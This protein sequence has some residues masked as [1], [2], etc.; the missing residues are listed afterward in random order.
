ML[1]LCPLPASKR[2]IR[3]SALQ[4]VVAKSRATRQVFTHGIVRIGNKRAA[5]AFEEP[6][7][8]L[9]VFNSISVHERT[10]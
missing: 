6:G 8:V 2:R 5:V 10:R 3:K 4:T 7:L 1:L 9:D